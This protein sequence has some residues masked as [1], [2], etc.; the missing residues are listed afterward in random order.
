MAIEIIPDQQQQKQGYNDHQ[1][2]GNAVC[3]KGWFWGH[4]CKMVQRPIAGNYCRVTKAGTG[5]AGSG[6]KIGDTHLA[7]G[8]ART[9]GHN[10]IKSAA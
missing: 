5:P 7:M 1:G 2:C 10:G 4:E 6:D 8:K 3:E 9:C